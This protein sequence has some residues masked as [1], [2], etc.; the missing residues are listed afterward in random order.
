MWHVPR[1]AVVKQT[2]SILITANVTGNLRHNLQT[3]AEY[4]YLLYINN[5]SINT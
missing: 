3:N 1:A 2:E 5:T 4:I